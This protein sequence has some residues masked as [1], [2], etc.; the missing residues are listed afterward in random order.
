MSNEYKLYE[1][2]DGEVLV[3]IDEMSNKLSLSMATKHNVISTE[4]LTPAEMLKLLMRGIKAVSY[5][6]SEEE[7]NEMFS[8]LETYPF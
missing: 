5:W 2:L 8:K 4:E 1:D 7:F 3:S 6:M